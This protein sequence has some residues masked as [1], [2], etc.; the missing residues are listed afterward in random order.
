MVFLTPADARRMEAAEEHGALSFAGA[1]LAENPDC[2]AAWEAL[3]GGHM[4]FIA[5]DS[6]IGRAHGLG[7]TGKVAEGDIEKIEEFYFQRG[8]PAQVDV[9]AYADPSLIEALGRRGFQVAE[10]NQTL[11]RWIAP[12][13]RFS[14]K[15]EGI[16]IR[17]VRPEEVRTWSSVLAHVFFGDRAADFQELFTPWPAADSS[18]CLAAFDQGEMV[19]GA[20]GLIVPAYN[21]AALFGAG[22]LP[23]YRNRGIQSAFMQRRLRSAQQAGCDLAVVLTMPGTVSQRNVERAGFRLAYTKVVVSKAPPR[24][25]SAGQG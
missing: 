11:A 2:G 22:T 9:S 4:V 20:A 7:F 18:M 25:L 8:A 19:A 21:L 3:G 24:N 17:H 5:K 12:K 1:L 14:A 16:E 6:P 23:Q 10:F 15:V 13:E